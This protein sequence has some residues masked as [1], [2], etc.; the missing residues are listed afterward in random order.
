M[1]GTCQHERLSW[2]SGDYYLFCMG[3]PA[4]WVMRGTGPGDEPGTEHMTP[5]FDQS[6]DM[7]REGGDE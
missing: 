1:T 4:Q 6:K 5:G 7:V 2:G 3:C